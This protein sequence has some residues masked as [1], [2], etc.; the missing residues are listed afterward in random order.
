[1]ELFSLQEAPSIV[2][3]V[4]LGDAPEKTLPLA[5]RIAQLAFGDA[6]VAAITAVETPS[7]PHDVLRAFAALPPPFLDAFNGALL[8]AD[9]A[10][11]VFQ[12]VMPLLRVLHAALFSLPCLPEA[13][14]YFGCA[15][16]AVLPLLAAND[17]VRWW[18]S[19]FGVKDR[20]AVLQAL[21]SSGAR[22]LF[23]VQVSSAVAL[24][25]SALVILPAGCRFRVAGVTKETTGPQ[26]DL[27]TVRFVETA[28]SVLRQQ[29]RCA[30]AE[31][32]PIAATT[33]AGEDG[34]RGRKRSAPTSSPTTDRPAISF[35]LFSMKGEP[36]SKEVTEGDESQPQS[37][38]RTVLSP[39]RPPVVPYLKALESATSYFDIHWANLGTLLKPGE[40]ILAR[41]IP[42]TQQVCY[43]KSIEVNPRHAPGWSNLGTTVD[44]KE[45][46]RVMGAL[47]SKRALYL[48]A[49][50]SDPTYSPAWGNLGNVMTADEEILLRGELLN[51]RQVY[52]KG[53]ESDQKNAYP[54]NNLGVALLHKSHDFVTINGTKYDALAC[55]ARA[56]MLDPKFV[57]PWKN[58]GEQLRAGQTTAV[59][60]EHCLTNVQCLV[61][62]L[63]LDRARASTWSYLAYT[64]RDDE[65]VTISGTNMS[66]VDVYA[67]ALAL[68]PKYV[69]TWRNVAATLREDQKVVV[70]G[71]AFSARECYLKAITLAPLDGP[72]WGYLGYL[73]GRDDSVS[74]DG[75]SYT[76][77]DLYLKSLDLDNKHARVW[78]YLADL[79]GGDSI[80][81][82]GET[83][84]RIDCCVK[85]VESD[86][87]FRAAWRALVDTMDKDA[88][89]TVNGVTL[90]YLDCCVRMVETN[91]SDGP[92]W[93]YF[94]CVTGNAT[95]FIDGK[96]RTAADCYIKSLELLPTSSKAW[97]NLGALGQRAVVVNGKSYTSIGCFEEALRIDPKYVRCY[98]NLAARLLSDEVV[99][100]NGVQFSKAQLGSRAVE[101]SPDDPLTWRDVSECLDNDEAIEYEGKRYTLFECLYKALSLDPDSVEVLTALVDRLLDYETMGKIIP[102]EA[103][104][105]ACVEGTS[106]T[107]MDR[108][109][110][111]NSNPAAGG[112]DSECVPQSA[113]KSEK[114]RGTQQLRTAKQ[115][116]LRLLELDADSAFVWTQLANTM[117]GDEIIHADGKDWNRF[118]VRGKAVALEPKQCVN[119]HRMATTLG[120]KKTARIPWS[121]SQLASGEE[122]K[123]YDDIACFVRATACHDADPYAWIELADALDWRPREER[124]VTIHGDVFTPRGLRIKA[125]GLQPDLPDL[126]SRLGLSLHYE[127]NTAKR[128]KGPRQKKI[129][130]DG[131]ELPEDP[132]S[133][134]PA[135]PPE[136]CNST[137][138]GAV[139]GSGTHAKAGGLSVE[140]EGQWY[141]PLDCFVHAV[142]IDPT[143][144]QSWVDLAT[145][146]HDLG[147]DGTNDAHCT[148]EKEEYTC[149]SSFAKALALDPTCSSAW[150]WLAILC[151]QADEEIEVLGS[152]YSRLG[153]HCR[154]VECAPDKSDLWRSLGFWLD[155]GSIAVG[156]EIVTKGVCYARAVERSAND[157]WAWLDLCGC[158]K[159]ADEVISIHGKQVDLKDALRQYFQCTFDENGAS[160]DSSYCLPY[161]FCL[162]A[163]LRK[164]GETVTVGGATI[165]G[166]DCLQRFDKKCAELDPTE[167]AAAWSSISLLPI[168]WPVQWERAPSN[169]REAAL[170][171]LA[172][173]SK[174]VAA[175]HSCGATLAEGETFTFEGKE[176]SLGECEGKW[177]EPVQ[178]KAT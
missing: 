53:I 32:K 164:K 146:L 71:E 40:T 19:Q 138:E 25:D 16:D 102:T 76:K 18:G 156:G 69:T 72:S 134:N 79:I 166:D 1:M 170:K 165:T 31:I 87:A 128:E 45:T 5:L 106:A 99:S 174:S 91:S 3:I 58:L 124:K 12:A 96:T 47:Y 55:F 159:S 100:V 59:G 140:V 42:V 34:K 139:S 168:P 122:D 151:D 6:C 141:G 177:K 148:V 97:N 39:V 57:D 92:T 171:A 119:W 105:D 152:K 172:C 149:R 158:F 74:I 28:V 93:S 30:I 27:V 157:Q 70:D 163:I 63:E 83:L 17:A 160:D 123:E 24:P 65:T 67:R 36:T 86:Y 115:A 15:G 88:S 9:R 143:R 84:T 37:A 110:A 48:K 41:S 108:S 145:H 131:E 175:W 137:H 38:S 144:A 121:P 94:P 82:Q 127:G 14:M 147:T 35:A 50:E 107:G 176:Y 11:S 154:A 90:S 178:P 109:A 161:W 20:G 113:P 64:M 126:W 85:A 117:A 13:T 120:Q 4:G 167:Q 162:G 169:A 60:R 49:L 132:A 81:V 116:L 101:I 129:E 77:K 118:A 136:G 33:P 7:D 61:R 51:K 153:L 54:W 29:L 133:I 130:R 43:I 73:L 44:E 89:I 104:D 46:I 155:E 75:V 56:A 26:R 80:A 66:K 150:E 62:A 135:D 98:T 52:A 10:S 8:C 142:E 23:E 22:T 2:P 21:P 103:P 125:I 78:Q 95:A 68:R 114:Y 112:V 173:D 111:S